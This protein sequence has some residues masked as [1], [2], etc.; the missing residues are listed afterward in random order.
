MKCRCGG[1]TESA[2][3]ANYGEEALMD[4]CKDCGKPAGLSRSTIWIVVL[5]VCFAMVVGMTCFL[6]YNLT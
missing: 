1:Q 5:A 6:C 2:Y 3:S 4:I